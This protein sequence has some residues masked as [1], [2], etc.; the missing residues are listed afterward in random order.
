[1]KAFKVV[2]LEDIQKGQLLIVE[3][4]GILQMKVSMLRTPSGTAL[5]NFSKGDILNY[6]PTRNTEHIAVH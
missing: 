5:R 2:A 4:N 3:K 6:D 1:M